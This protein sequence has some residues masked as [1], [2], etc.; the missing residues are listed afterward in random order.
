MASP[1]KSLYWTHKGSV[2]TPK[3]KPGVSIESE[4]LAG[5]SQSHLVVVNLRPEDEGT[6]SCVTDVSSPASIELI[7]GEIFQY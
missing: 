6:Y 2:I 5:V 7:I 3:S 4:K 1:P